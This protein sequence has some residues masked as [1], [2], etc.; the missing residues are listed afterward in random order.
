[1]PEAEVPVIAID[2][3]GGSGKGTVSRAV[4]RRLGWHLLDSGALYRLVG[5]A[6]LLD[7]VA[8]DDEP[9]LSRVAAALDVRFDPWRGAEGEVYLRGREVSAEIRSEAAGA[10]ASRVA[11]LAAVR[12]ALITRQQAFRRPPGLVADGRDMGSCIFPQARLKVFLTASV[13]ERA[14]R[15]YN[16][17]K[18]KG[19][20]VSLAALSRDMAER[21]QRDAQRPVAPLQRCADAHLLDSTGLDIDAVV[22]RVLRWALQAYPGLALPEGS[23]PSNDGPE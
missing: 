3:P 15:R 10:A 1:M 13:E 23:V 8:L 22:S 12:S 6:A 16:Q 7:G 4:A 11:A 2:G 20:D 21:D 5:L 19:I 14:R 18:Q 9:A 17:L